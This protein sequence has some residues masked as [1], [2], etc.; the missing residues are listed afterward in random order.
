MKEVNRYI[1]I[2]IIIFCGCLCNAQNELVT[3][4]EA[5]FTLEKQHA[6]TF[7]YSEKTIEGYKVSPINNTLSFAESID[8]L[9]QQTSL[10]FTMQGT[11]LVLI[12]SPA[13]IALCGYIVDSET[14]NVIPFATIQGKDSATTANEGGY[15]SLELS[16]KNELVTIRHLGYKT[17]TISA[18]TFLSKDCPQY[19]ISPQ[20]EQLNAVLLTSYLVQGISKLN[21]GA[22]QIDFDKFTAL[23]GLIETDVLQA[24]QALPGVQSINETVSN[25]N[26][27]GGTNDQNLVLWDDIKMYQTGHFFGL[28][29]AFNPQITQQ[30][31]IQKNG[32]A[33]SYTDGVSGSIKM[34][35]EAIVNNTFKLNAGANLIDINVFADIPLSNSSS[36]Q[37]GGR[38]SLEDFVTTPTYETYFT[39]IAQDT[40]V[41]SNMGPV[42]NTDRNFDFYDTSLRWL[43]E[44]SESDRLRV[45]FLYINNNLEFNENATI[46][47][48][49]RSRQSSVDQNS[50][51]AGVFYEKDWSPVLNTSFQIYETDYTL[52][53]IN[54]NILDSQRFLQE[55]KVSETGIKT[56]TKYKLTAQ[57]TLQIG[58]E[59]IETKVTNLDDVDVPLVRTLI[60]EVVRTHSGFASY[61]ASSKNKNSLLS[62]GIRYNYLDKFKKSI[63]EPRLSFTQKFLDHF[64]VELAGEF[65]HQIAS[66][67]VNFQNDFLGIEKRRWQLSNDDSIPVLQS[68]QYSTG[69]NFS[70]RG[71]L[72]TTELYYK[73]VDGITSQAQGFQNQFEFVKTQGSYTSVGADF[74]LR[75]KFDAVSMW[76]SYSLMNSEYTF[77]TLSPQAI[78][79]NYN[80][81]H[82]LTFGTTYAQNG[83]KIAAGIH[84][85]SGNPT[86]IPVPGN[87]I[88]DG[89]INYGLTNA[90]RFDDYFRVD[91]SILYRFTIGNS[92]AQ[93][94]VS[95]WNI[96]NQTNTI[97]SFY[98]IN[99]QGDL[100]ENTQTA[101]GVTPNASVRI[102]L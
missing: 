73:Y 18:T 9:R 90:E 52:R 77:E 34:E 50:L 91:G 5:I 74:L 56:I 79:S 64:S 94:G 55:N 83:L 16:S 54:A 67:V 2:I 101:L 98:R 87:E 75:K 95:V 14:Q 12:S 96:L 40:E 71:W 33:A 8:S 35:T 13:S 63:L 41:E 58:Y 47:G 7:N 31:T 15:F 48:S 61:G 25:I 80:I 21:N 32:T 29:S 17:S 28:I 72:F 27:R 30:V 76:L 60:S 26:I 69:F 84:W 38:K 102:T 39:R 19:A 11:N 86:S 88:V 45:N 65:K 82:N 46:D 51:G 93:A 22:L 43:Y 81:P 97:S 6:Y 57:E 24:A 78:P 53:A 42:V 59:L 10:S 70:N 37:V 1:L 92:E 62:A 20:T 85:R 36:L 3:L 23:P 89:S 99:G 49:L 44:I 100:V 4:K 66:Q 68:Q